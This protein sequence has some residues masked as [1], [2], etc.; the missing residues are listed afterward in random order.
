M[1]DDGDAAPLNWRGIKVV[2]QQLAPD[3]NLAFR[4]AL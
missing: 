2:G 1:V 3:E 4:L